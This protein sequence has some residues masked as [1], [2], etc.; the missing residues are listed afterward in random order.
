MHRPF[1]ESAESAVLVRRMAVINQ[2]HANGSECDA[3]GAKC[4]GFFSCTAKA[5]ER[6]QPESCSALPACCGVYSRA[7]RGRSAFVITEIEL[8]LIVIPASIGLSVHPRNGYS[9]PAAIG[10]PAKL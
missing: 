9:A 1:L 10:S 3:Q 2:G 6:R 7:L 8:M 5:E 4:D